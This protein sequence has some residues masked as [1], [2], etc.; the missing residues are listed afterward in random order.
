MRRGPLR[1][2]LCD[3]PGCPERWP[4]GVHGT[5]QVGD[6]GHVGKHI[7][8]F[9]LA[10]VPH[11]GGAIDMVWCGRCR[12]ALCSCPPAWCAHCVMP[13][14]SSCSELHPRCAGLACHCSPR[15]NVIKLRPGWTTDG[16]SYF[17]DA[18]ALMVCPDDSRD[19]WVVRGNG[20][21]FRQGYQV[22]GYFVFAEQAMVFAEQ[23]GTRHADEAQAPALAPGWVLRRNERGQWYE[24][25]LGWVVQQSVRSQCKWQKSLK[26]EPGWLIGWYDSCDAALAHPIARPGWRPVGDA[27]YELSGSDFFVWY[28]ESADVYRLQ[29][30]DADPFMHAVDAI[31][32]AE[33]LARA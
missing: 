19:R 7:G 16:E 23:L 27:G 13:R 18:I 28:D 10:E 3:R 17:N 20:D 22:C 9:Q 1:M 26:V 6:Y 25:T 15:D 14:D 30:S 2:R 5:L 29:G 31:Y 21:P 32:R 12:V 11:S 24:H 33:E 4:C 8:E